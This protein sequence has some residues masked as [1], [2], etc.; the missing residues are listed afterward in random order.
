MTRTRYTADIRVLGG[1]PI[2]VEYEW[3]MAEPDVGIREPY[4]YGEEIVAVNGRRVKN[5]DW[6]LKR[7]IANPTEYD[8]LLDQIRTAGEY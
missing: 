6:V 5:T 2:T 8:N 7:L 1:L 3:A 4:V